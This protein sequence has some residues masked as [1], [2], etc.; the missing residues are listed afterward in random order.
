MSSTV[1]EESHELPLHIKI[2]R[3]RAGVLL[4]ILSDALSVMAI[5]AAGGYLNAL[6]VLGQFK[7]PNEAV[8]NIIPGILVAILLVVSGAAYYLW[9]RTIRRQAGTIQQPLFIV[10][11]LTT[12]VA[13][14]VQI[15]ISY[16]LGFGSPYH[17][18][19]SVIIL[20]T[21]FTSVHL[22]LSGIVGLL[23]FGRIAR[24]RQTG[25]SYVV[26][27]VGYWWYYT[28]IASLLLWIF[29]LILS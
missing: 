25:H 21:W 7:V 11:W 24:G 18:Y 23:L 12:I 26:E 1:H 16:T 10:A 8:P 5:L 4:L 2:A 28:I 9:E 29:S 15:Y 13:L 19:E 20:L 17:A 22:L 3:A 27:V 6:N 14:V